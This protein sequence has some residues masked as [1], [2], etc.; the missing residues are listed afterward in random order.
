MFK[1]LHIPLTA[2][3][4]ILAISTD[5]IMWAGEA[6]LLRFLV[7]LLQFS[8]YHS[9]AQKASNGEGYKQ[10]APGP[11]HAGFLL[12]RLVKLGQ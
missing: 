11:A 10:A 4:L 1:C 6:G 3:D 12:T 7:S 8:T 9:S 5:G 2:R